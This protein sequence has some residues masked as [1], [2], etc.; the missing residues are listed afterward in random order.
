MGYQKNTRPEL[1]KKRQLVVNATDAAVV[2]DAALSSGSV[3]L[4]TAPIT[5]NRV[6]TL[7]GGRLGD[8]ISVTRTAAATG[9]FNL[10]VGGLKDLAVGEW[11]EVIHNG[12][13]WVLLQFGSL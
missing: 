10:D 13:A 4:Q 7:P 2:L 3:L 11:C 1:D 9:A 12:S 5:E 6:V 8:R